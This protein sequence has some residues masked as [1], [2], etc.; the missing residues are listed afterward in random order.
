MLTRTCATIWILFGGSCFVVSKY[1]LPGSSAPPSCLPCT[2]VFQVRA[3][4]VATS[5]AAPARRSGREPTSPTLMASSRAPRTTYRSLAIALRS[6]CSR[7][8][9]RRAR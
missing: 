5:T 8:L 4:Y 1:K 2:I 3:A 7:A 9:V 6:G